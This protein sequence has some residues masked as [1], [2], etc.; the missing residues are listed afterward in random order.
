MEFKDLVPNRIQDFC[1]I[2][3]AK[4]MEDDK[5]AAERTRNA[6]ETNFEGTDTDTDT[7]TRDQ[8]EGTDEDID[9]EDRTPEDTERTSE[10]TDRTPEDTEV[11]T[12]DVDP[13]GQRETVGEGEGLDSNQP[14]AESNLA[15]LND[16]EFIET[17]KQEAESRFEQDS[18]GTPGGLDRQKDRADELQK[19]IAETIESGME[20]N[21]QAS[22][23]HARETLKREMNREY[24]NEFD[25]DGFVADNY[26]DGDL[27]SV[28]VTDLENSII[29]KLMEAKESDDMTVSL[30]AER[31]AGEAQAQAGPLE[32]VDQYQ[33]SEVITALA[34]TNHF[35]DIAGA[36]VESL[37][38]A[39]DHRAHVF[40]MADEVAEKVESYEDR[41]AARAET[42]P[43]AEKKEKIEK[44][45]EALVDDYNRL[46]NEMGDSTESI[47]NTIDDFYQEEVR[48]GDRLQ[49][50]KQ[51][52][53]EL[54]G[55]KEDLHWL[56]TDM[57][58]NSNS[59]FDDSD[60]FKPSSGS[61]EGRLEDRYDA[62]ESKTERLGNGF[63]DSEGLFDVMVESANRFNEVLGTVD[64]W[65]EDISADLPPN[66]TDIE[67]ID[68]FAEE[69]KDESG[70]VT[71]YAQELGEAVESGYLVQEDGHIGLS[72]DLEAVADYTREI[73]EVWDNDDYSTQEA[74]NKVSSYWNGEESLDDFDSTLPELRDEFAA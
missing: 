73:R 30:M 16:E 8:D 27:E 65:S 48:L 4:D 54:L 13:E 44:R 42:A 3:E 53:N 37:T 19:A 58:L 67:R 29:P 35:K 24:D 72:E 33:H 64:D 60:E 15:E 28:G 17:I 52:M 7:S 5:K 56:T 55:L 21:I 45:N 61:D 36:E 38:D 34:N 47:A 32:T 59:G 57:R 26:G 49:K 40:Y 14:V 70:A 18:D 22:E 62:L 74:Y 1:G 51:E 20:S 63:A 68:S 6:V 39:I 23:D 50:A 9:H 41:M 2:S 71:Q 11:P 43:N 25:E 31:M 69:V 46:L 66:F 10:D 12:P